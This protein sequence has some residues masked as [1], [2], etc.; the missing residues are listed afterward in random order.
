LV[1][2]LIANGFRLRQEAVIA[3]VERVYTPGASGYTLAHEFRNHLLE[4][5]VSVQDYESWLAKPEACGREG[6]YS[7]GVMTFVGLAER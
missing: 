1:Y 5:G 4:T 6:W 3:N 2:L 7:Y